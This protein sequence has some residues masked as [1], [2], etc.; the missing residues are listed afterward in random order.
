M[1]LRDFSN[2]S[3]FTFYL[4]ILQ[5]RWLLKTLKVYV[6]GTV[7]IGLLFVVNMITSIIFIILKP[8]MR[9]T[10]LFHNDVL[11]DTVGGTPV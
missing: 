5:V 3:L 2:Y 7:T 6:L 4:H 1:L 9:K 8:W 10:T 11:D